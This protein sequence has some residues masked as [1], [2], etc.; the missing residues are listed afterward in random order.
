MPPRPP[1]LGEFEVVVLLAVLH[2]TERRE[3]AYGSTIRDVIAER[4]NRPVARGAIYVTLDR[5]DAKKLLTS[6]LDA[7]G[8]SRDGR[9]RR[10]FSVTATGLAAARQAVALV[11]RMQ[12]G[13]EPVLNR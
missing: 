3:P 1:V 9:P 4:T 10:L 13:L 8:P 2:L 5:L 6:R 11:N 12:S 7:G